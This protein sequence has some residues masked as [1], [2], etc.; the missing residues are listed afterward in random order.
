MI[1]ALSAIYGSAGSLI[2]AAFLYACKQFS[3]YHWNIDIQPIITNTLKSTWD[4]VPDDPSLTYNANNYAKNENNQYRCH[5]PKNSNGGN[6]YLYTDYYISGDRYFRFRLHN[7]KNAKVQII[8]KFYKSTKNDWAES[9]FLNEMHY[10]V[11]TSKKVHCFDEFKSQISTH[12]VTK[13]QLG[14]HISSINDSEDCECSILDCYI[15]KKKNIINLCGGYQLS[16][17]EKSSS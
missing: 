13:E 11:S 15:G 14:L 4:V 10:D 17:Y 16:F 7:V 3:M 2:F 5:I 12:D 8:T 1:D 9:D 6:V